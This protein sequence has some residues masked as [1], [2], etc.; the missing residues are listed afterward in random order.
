MVRFVH[1]RALMR[2]MLTLLLASSLV[3]CVDPSNLDGLVIALPPSTPDNLAIT[4]IVV[5]APLA[6]NV[7]Y[8]YEWETDGANQINDFTDLDSIGDWATRPGETWTVT[9][10]PYVGAQEGPAAVATTLVSDAG[11]DS[12]ND[13]DGFTENQGDCD[14]ARSTVF[15]GSDRDN[16]GFPGCLWSWQDSSE[17]DCDDGDS[18]VNPGRTIDDATSRFLVDDDCD[19]RVDEDDIAEGDVLVTEVMAQAT[20][21]G[22]AW[23]EVVNRSG[24]ARQLQN[25]T[26]APGIS[27]LPPVL[28]GPTQRAVLCPD[29]A[30]AEGSGVSCLNT[31]VFTD[32][33]LFTEALELSV[34]T[35]IGNLLVAEVPLA[36]I[37][38]AA[39]TAVG[40]D[41]LVTATFDSAADPASWCLASVTMGNG[42]LG[43]PGASNGA[44]P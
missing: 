10:T 39:G 21:E 17:Q 4:P 7:R 15:P 3:G 36:E 32:D 44:C 43:T 12:D 38:F 33:A 18:F 8:R 42:D 19:G 1:R 31:K 5:V 23:I 34:E 11:R 27:R 35:R 6:A 29:P 28:L 26:L 24:V 9:V 30:L 2:R 20:V 25:W 14:D 41:E 22:G 16:D 13:G 37:P 40:V